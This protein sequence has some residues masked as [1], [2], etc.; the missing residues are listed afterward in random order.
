MDRISWLFGRGQERRIWRE[1]TLHLQRPLGKTLALTLLM[2]LLLGGAAELTARSEPFQRLLRE[3]GMG[4]RHYQL[5]RKLARLDA[6][7]KNSGPIDCLILG[8]SMVDVGFDPHAF[9][10]GYKE[11]TGQDIH[12]FNFGIDAST[13]VSAAAIAQ[14]LVEDY[15]PRILIYG[16]DARDYAVASEDNDPA[17][18]LES[19]WVRYRL[20]HFSL[21]GWLLDHSYFYRYRHYLFRLSRLYLE[22]TLRSQTTLN[23]EITADGHTPLTTVSTYIN[24]PPDPKDDSFEVTYTFSIFSSFEM[25]EENLDALERIMAHNNQETQV[26]ITEMPVADG[27][28][29]FFG[30]GKD[31][32]Q[33]F[34]T[35][36]GQLAQ[37]HQVPF[38]QTT[39]LDLIPDDGWVD[40]SHVNTTGAAIFSNWLGQQVGE[41][42]NDWLLQNQTVSS[43]EID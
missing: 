22:E 25:L 32:H 1:S 8:S 13:A 21:D 18:I 16:T 30:N 2:L 6:I 20:G 17:V 29:Y 33:R 5:G 24:D 4:S 38:W 23:Y 9:R 39:A 3:P 37:A 40:Y 10:E 31:D 11:A 14:I 43:P 35:Q 19:N 7:I 36:V 27:L 15:R 28:Y 41:A 34:L 42:Q 12:C 26:I